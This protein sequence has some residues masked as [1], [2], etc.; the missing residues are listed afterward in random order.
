MPCHTPAALPFALGLD[1]GGSGTQ[2]VLLRGGERVGAGTVVPLTAALLAT[3]A[4]EAA[5]HALRDALPA[6]PPPLLRVHAGLPGISAGTPQA[7]AAQEGFAAALGLAPAQVSVESDLELAYRAHFAPGEGVLVYAGTGSIA[8]HVTAGGE[9]LRAGGRGYRIG[10][11]GA[12]TSLGRGAL[13]CLTDA[14][15]FGAEATGP[16]A[17]EVAAITGGLDWDTLRAYTYAA[18]GASALARLAPAVGRAAGRGDAAAL[19]LLREAAASLTELGR[20]VQAR[21]GEVPV[22]FTGGRCGS[23]RSSPPC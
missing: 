12:G 9:R 20:R 7:R 1:A 18:P 5:L 14:L 19:G 11:D 22:R 23:V 3:P 15:D 10:D 17:E 6:L 16:L 4:G 13:R 8:Y 21:A 2:W